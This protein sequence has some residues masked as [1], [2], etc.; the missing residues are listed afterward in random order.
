MKIPKRISP[1]PIVEV[2]VEIRFE[3]KI[4]PDAIFGLVYNSLKGEYPQVKKLPILE[5]PDVIRSNEPGLKFKPYNQLL[6]ENFIAQ[7]G[8]RVFSLSNRKEYVGWSEFYGRITSSFSKLAELDMM[9]NVARLGIRYINFFRFDIFE[10]INLE[11][12]MNRKA[13]PSTQTVVRAELKDGNFK[14]VLHI[15]NKAEVTIDGKRNRGSIID[16]DTVLEQRMPD[17]FGKMQGILQEGHEK[18]KRLFFSLLKTE[19]LETLNP[20]Y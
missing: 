14:N 1:C 15:A 16:I 6:N 4:P 11:I 10:K 13:L 5:I 7:I 19:Y 18:E 17:F 8:P 3:P 2:I 9:S 20:E 12:L